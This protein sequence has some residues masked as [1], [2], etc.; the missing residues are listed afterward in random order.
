MWSEI[1]TPLLREWQCLKIDGED[2][3]KIMEAQPLV[4]K[5]ATVK[6]PNKNQP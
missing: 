5:Q 3:E 4:A 1:E 2:F 6:A